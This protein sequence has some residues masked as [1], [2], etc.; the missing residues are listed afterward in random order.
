MRVVQS[1]GAISTTSINFSQVFKVKFNKLNQEGNLAYEYNPF[2]NLRTVENSSDHIKGELVD[3]DTN[4]LQFSLHHPVNIECQP[5]YDGTVNLIL[6]DDVNTPKM[7]NSRFTCL[8]NNTYKIIERYKNNNTNIY[9][10]DPVQFE[11]DTSLYKRITKIPQVIFEGVESGGVNKV[12]NYN[13]YFTLSDVDGNET[14]FIAESG[15]VCC[16]IGSVNSPTSI[17]GGLMDENSN[18]LIKLRVTNIDTAYDYV[19]VYYTR[20]TSGP[21]GVLVTKAVKIDRD[22]V[23]KSSSCEIVLSGYDPEIDINLEDINAQYFLASTV[24]TQAQCQNRL[25]L[26]NL[27]RPEIPYK[28]LRDLAL[29]FIPHVY[30]GDSIGYVDYEYKDKTNLYEYYNPWNIYYRLGYWPGEIYRFSVVF[31]MKDYSLSPAFDTRGVNNLSVENNFTDIPLYENGARNYI[32]INED[33]FLLNGDTLENVKGTIRI[34][35]NINPIHSDSINPIGIEF[36][37]N[38]DVLEE[39]KKY[40]RGFFIVRQK[41]IPT[42]LAQA[43]TVYLDQNSHLPCIEYKKGQG[44]VESFI[45]SNRLL[46]HDFNKRILLSSNVRTE[47]A[48]CPEAELKLPFFNQ[49]FT[50]SEFTITKAPNQPFEHLSAQDFDQRHFYINKYKDLGE[51]IKAIQGIKITL[52]EDGT[53]M[54]TSGTQKFSA[55]AGEGE[56]AWRV[57][58]MRKDSLD[59]AATNIV[60]GNFGTYIGIEDFNGYNNMINIRVSDYNDSRMDQ[61]FRI[62]FT[63]ETPFAAVSERV[64]LSDRTVGNIVCYRGDCYIGNF[65]HRMQRNFQDPEAPVNDLIVDETTWKENYSIDDNEKN[66]DINRGDV[67]AVEIGHWATFKCLA[68]INISLRDVDNNYYNELGLTGRPRAF[69]PLYE[70]SWTGESKIPESSLYNSGQANTLS[71]RYNYVMPNVPYLKNEFDNRILYSDIFVNDAFKNGYRVFKSTQFQDYTREHGS[72][73]SLKSF[74]GNILCVFEHGVALIPVNERVVSGEGAGGPAFINTANV[75]PLNPR[76]L[77]TN[78]GSMWP[79][80]VILTPNFMYGV[81]TV[82]KKIWRTNGETFEVISDFKI[83]KYLNDNITLKER[84]KTPIIGIRNVKTHYNAYK[85]DVM[86]TFYDNLYGIEENVWNIC[87]SEVLGKWIT[88]YSWVPSY[89]GNIDNIFFSFDRDT[90]KAIAKLG[91][92][93]EQYSIS[94]IDSEMSGDGIVLDNIMIQSPGLV[95]DLNVINRVLK[96]NILNT[97]TK[98]DSTLLFTF[99]LQKNIFSKYFYIENNKL[100]AKEDYPRDK[101]IYLDIY[102]DLNSEEISKDPNLSQHLNG[103]KEYIT[104]NRGQFSDTIAVVDSNFANATDES[105]RLINLTTDF[106]KHGKAGIIDIQE[107]LKPCFWYG[108]QHPF[109]FEFIVNDNPGIHKIFENLNI[110]SNKAKPESFHYQIVGEVYGFNK[111][112]P[113]IYYRQEATKELYQNLGSDIIFNRD[114]TSTKLDQQ[115]PST[116]FPWYYERIDTFDKIYDSYQQKQSAFNKDYQ[117]MT[118]TEVVYDDNLG[119]YSLVTHCKGADLKEVG[120]LRGNMQYKE[121]IWE[122]EIR[123]INYV[124]KN[125]SKWNKVPQI[126]LNNIPNDIEKDEIS[127]NDL[128]SEYD[129]TDVTLP[130]DGWTARKETRIRDKYIR[131]KVRYSGEDK[132]IISALRTIY[133]IS[134]A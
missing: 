26:G 50:G 80:S 92:T 77:S 16:Y 11:L 130:L 119:E 78:Y 53:K 67:N 25:F 65:T 19:K 58:Y 79:E 107:K 61:Y 31:I 70:L 94:S 118:G 2:R 62:R 51:Q 98:I 7:I 56:E 96:D 113:N 87:F 110:I 91:M 109:E 1:G 43:L 95:G 127:S 85:Q 17:R 12:G 124:Q 108:K 71:Y 86:F 59:T 100:Y 24:K 88:Q 34:D 55:R 132:A 115:T 72:I 60:R 37:F 117:N 97:S 8:E 116:L 76:M 90:S 128:P 101:V 75:L 123:P 112:K 20:T 84:E 103:W 82:A 68:N 102:C 6:N 38:L 44:F 66:G 30:N 73:V 28:E 83:Q 14:D 47:A 23:I 69:H 32:E 134:Y 46:T 27:S 48:I 81:D 57:S 121:D 131:I 18:K 33:T 133:S 122:V 64:D 111:D 114:Y 89:S 129:I 5:S 10:N 125:E 106:W 42:I 15:T 4:L 29:R 105:G 13:F 93:G 36:K 126:I 74:S 22:F 120:R 40:C 99:S 52:V 3:F 63:D 21:D 104:V 54:T 49:L 41:R 35:E 9:R 39:L 45:D